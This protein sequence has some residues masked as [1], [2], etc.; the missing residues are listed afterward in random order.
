[1]SF[2]RISFLLMLALLALGVFPAGGQPQQ[3]DV[4]CYWRPSSLDK[5]WVG[6]DIPCLEEVTPAGT[7]GELTFTALAAA[8][9]GTL[10]AARPLAGEVWALT[11]TDGDGLPET[12]ALAVS[13]LTRPNGLAWFDDALYIAAGSEIAMLRA[14]ELRLLVADLPAGAGLWTGGI[15]VGS[16]G[17]G[18]AR[19]YVG[20]GAAC[21]TCETDETG[22]GAVWSFALDGSDGKIEAT[23]LRQPAALAFLDGE[24]WVVDSAPASAF[25]QPWLDEI[26]RLTPGADFGFPRCLGTAIGDCAGVTPPVFALPTGSTPLALAA[27]TS[28]ILPAFTGSFLVALSGST[29]QVELRGYTFAQASPATGA[30]TVLIPQ[31]TDQPGFT[32]TDELNYRTVGFYPARPYGVAVSGL[33]WVYLS[34]SNGRILAIRPQSEIVN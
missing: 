26:N 10:Y 30:L 24:L 2:R 19:I 21:D 3:P 22:R 9:D 18:E 12:P 6:P 27:Y 32:T 16:R 8:P 31:T 33:G 13:G 1:M 20:T 15:A 7:E 29:G 25:D 23:G 28:D 17:E 14:G 4:A 5:P 11:D 34:L